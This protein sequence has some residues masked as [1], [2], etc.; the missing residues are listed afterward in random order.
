MTMQRREVASAILIDT[1]GR[2]LLQQRDDI[3]GIM[4]PGTVGLFGGHREGGESYL[5]CVVREVEEEISFG[6]PAERFKFIT[7]HTEP[8]AD[9]RG[10][11]LYGEFFFATDIPYDRLTITEGALLIV[12]RK[13]IAT[14][15]PRFVPTT[16]FVMETFLEQQI[17]KP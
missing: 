6:V 13:D 11:T 8:N 7:N 12:E 1:L 5:E 3:P 4:H 10:R 2:F 16:R 9:E 15:T 17:R 14:L